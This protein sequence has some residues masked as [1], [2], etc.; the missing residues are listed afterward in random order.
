MLSTL[1]AVVAIAAAAP[2]VRAQSTWNPWQIGGAAGIAFPTG[3]LDNIANVGYNV[4]VAVGY[5]Q[6]RN[7]IGFRGEAAF[8][9]FGRDGPGRS[10]E[11]PAFTGNVIYN[12]QGIS[13]SPYVIGGVGLYR[14]NI[15][16]GG[17]SENDIG[18]NI[19][20][21][22]RLPFS[23]SFETFVEA[24]YHHVTLDQGSWGFIPI[25]IGIMW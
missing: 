2:N 15:L 1:S 25:T 20:G 3:D 13:Y 11:I 19:G 7:P 16:P 6:R 8:N 9:G 22:I 10:I 5:Q 21:G 24:R 4:A 23:R 12:F 17:D 18:F 14:P